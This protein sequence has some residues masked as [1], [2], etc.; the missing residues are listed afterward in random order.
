LTASRRIR[1]LPLTAG[2]DALRGSMLQRARL[3]ELDLQI[4]IILGWGSS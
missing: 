3:P 2:I 4:A 1:P